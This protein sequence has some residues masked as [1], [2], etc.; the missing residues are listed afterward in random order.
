[1]WY[2]NEVE[3]TFS[4]WLISLALFK[5]KF[6]VSQAFQ[7]R[8]ESLSTLADFYIK[9]ITHTSM[10]TVSIRTVVVV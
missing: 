8:P 3:N 10:H 5:W 7:V 6:A 4:L 9:V 2:V 1:M